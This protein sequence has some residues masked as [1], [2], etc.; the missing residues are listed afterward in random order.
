MVRE[1]SIDVANVIDEPRNFSQTLVFSACIIPDKDVALQMIKVLAD[2]GV[3]PLKEDTLKQSPLFYAAREGNSAVID[4]L[5]ARDAELVN[6][7]D[8]YGQTPIYYCVR[9]GHIQTTMQLMSKGAN[10]DHVD[11]KNQRPIYYAI[12]SNKFEMVKFLID[13][14]ANLQ[15]EDKKGITPTMWARK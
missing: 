9:E 1:S 6:R 7:Q 11:V 2:L 8:K 10:F 13:K 5:C 4:F 12:T 14:G 15:L 3:D